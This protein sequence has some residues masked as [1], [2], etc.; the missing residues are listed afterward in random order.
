MTTN[1]L[2]VPATCPHVHGEYGTVTD[3]DVVVQ[4]H[5]RGNRIAAAVTYVGADERTT[6]YREP[7]PHWVDLD[8]PDVDP[9]LADCSMPL[10]TVA[11]VS[12]DGRVVYGEDADILG[13]DVLNGYVETDSETSRLT[14]AGRDW[15]EGR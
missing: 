2:T 7:V 9:A 8:D 6:M 11:V 3:A 10:R 4:L 1:V 15:W 14:P 12:D 5:R 13:R